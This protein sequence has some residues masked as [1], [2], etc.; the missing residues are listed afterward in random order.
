MKVTRGI[1]LVELLIVVAVIS[2]LAIGLMPKLSMGGNSDSKISTLCSR[3]Q[4]VRA[5]ISVYRVQHLDRVPGGTK[6]VS[7]EQAMTN[8]T[9]VEGNLVDGGGCGPYM[10]EIP[11]NPF[12]DSSAVRIGGEAAGANTHGWRY[13]TKTDSFQADSSKPHAQL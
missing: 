6:D 1:T 3:L 13:D 10:E 5:Q 8:E 2:V 11:E 12:N 4:K 7:F 9:D